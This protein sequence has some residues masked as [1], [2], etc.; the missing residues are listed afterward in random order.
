MQV[1]LARGVEPPTNGLQNRCSTIELRQRK[2]FK[3]PKLLQRNCRQYYKGNFVY[4]TRN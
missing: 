3:I 4:F 1:Q 2:N